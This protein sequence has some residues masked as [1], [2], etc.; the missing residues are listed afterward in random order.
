MA[1]TPV[2]KYFDKRM[3]TVTQS[4]DLPRPQDHIQ[5]LSAFA[6]RRQFETPSF[7]AFFKALLSAR[8]SHVNT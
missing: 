7:Y 8:C 3:D 4:Q 5:R 1:K 2:Q 6:Y